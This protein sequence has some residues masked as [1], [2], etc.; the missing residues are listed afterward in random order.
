MPC[1]QC[2]H[3]TTLAAELAQ[4]FASRW[5]ARGLA[6]RIR[7]VDFEALC[8]EYRRLRKN[9]PLRSATNLL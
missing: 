5:P 4:L 3:M 1:H 6:V 2:E 9:A 8:D 7:A